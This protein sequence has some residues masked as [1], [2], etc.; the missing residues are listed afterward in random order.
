MP[1]ARDKAAE[2]DHVLYEMEM[3]VFSVFALLNQNKLSDAE[4]N[5]WIEC[6]ASHSRNLNE[7]FSSKL[8]PDN[9]M[10]ADHFVIWNYDYAFNGKLASRASQHVSHLTYGR[11][12]PGEKT[13]WPLDDFFRPL[14]Q[15]CTRFVG[16]IQK[17]DALM[18]FQ[19]NRQ[20]AANLVMLLRQFN[21]GTQ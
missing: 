11:E 8:F 1:K 13:G 5:L 21:F 7:F 18:A 19:Q 17:Q 9:Y 6:F 2:L 20:R 12:V 15:Q 10:K 16:L 14:H 4:R 3:L